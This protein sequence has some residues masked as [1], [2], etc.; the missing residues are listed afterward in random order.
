[1]TDGTPNP[2]P[3]TPHRR[4]FKWEPAAALI[5]LI[6]VSLWVVYDPA[7]GKGEP[8][9]IGNIKGV[10][11]ALPPDP[12]KPAES[13]Y[14]FEPRSG[15]PGQPMSSSEVARLFGPAVRDSLESSGRN[16]LF[17]V[18]KVTSWP[19]LAWVGLGLAGQAAFSGRMLLQWIASE[20]SRKSVVPAAFWWLSLFGAVALLA[21]FIWRQDAV[22]VLGQAPGLVIYARNLRLLAKQQRRA[23]RQPPA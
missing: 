23:L 12:T 8:V 5:S 21:Y 4:R 6:A 7:K 2:A 10:L 3:P 15:P 16:V 1:V 19:N 22:G 11:A 14:R 17:R 18:F 9:Q 13:F 20:K